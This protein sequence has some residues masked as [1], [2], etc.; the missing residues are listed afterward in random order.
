M[1]SSVVSVDDDLSSTMSSSSSS[2]DDE[3][4]HRVAQR[5]WEESLEQLQ[6][7]FAIVLLPFIGRWF[8]RRF[9]FLGLDF[10][11]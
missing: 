3:E 10:S 2:F 7:L 8:G 1:P 4:E 6:Q 11:K 9:S 5:E